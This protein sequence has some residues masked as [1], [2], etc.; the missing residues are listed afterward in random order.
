MTS[1]LIFDFLKQA[2]PREKFLSAK[3]TISGQHEAKMLIKIT[4]YYKCV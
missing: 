3:A 1:K 2:L 4:F